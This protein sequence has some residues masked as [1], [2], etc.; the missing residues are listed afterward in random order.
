MDQQ[1]PLT[2]KK[3]LLKNL[4]TKELVIRIEVAEREYEQTLRTEAT[5]KEQQYGFLCSGINDCQKVKSRLAELAALAPAD[6]KGKPMSAA[7]L[8]AWLT[9]Q[10]K[11]EPELTTLISGQRDTAYTMENN[12]ILVDV[13]K[14]RLE[15]MNRVLELKIAQIRFLTS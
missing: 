11:D 2:E 7:K 14:R 3:A 4:E 6:D 13:A 10:R 8:D 9:Q 1:D 12:R 5:Y 15:G